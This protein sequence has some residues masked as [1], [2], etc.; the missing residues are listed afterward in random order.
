MSRGRLV[1]VLPWLYASVRCPSG[2]RL[3]SATEPCKNCDA[4]LVHGQRYCAICGQK[5]P[6]PRLTLREILS[7]F[8]HAVAHVDRSAMSLI[9]Q[10]LVRPGTV[11]LEYVC[12]KR[13]RYFGPFAF[14]VVTVAFTSAVIAIS[15]FQAVTTNSPNRIADFLQHHVNWLFFVE[16]PMLAV[17]CRLIGIRERFNYAEYLV[18]VSYTAGMHILWY[19]VV[20]VPVWY[21]LHSDTVLMSRLFYVNLPIGPLYFAYGMFQ[22]LPGRRLSSAVNGLVAS[23]MT[24]AVTVGLVAAIST[25]FS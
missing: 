25:V 13:K 2:G 6:A 22:F 4:A 10:L 7:D 8:I 21:L 16:V 1:L 14:L 23:L 5:S 20:V 11:A 15:G 19:A 17:A 18:L 9:L 12:G 24:Q 3:A